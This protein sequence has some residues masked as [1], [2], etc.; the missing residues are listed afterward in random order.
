MA[1]TG[2]VTVTTNIIKRDGQEVSFDISKI[3]NA[4]KKANKEVEPIHQLNE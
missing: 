4:I 1:E 2:T 3:V